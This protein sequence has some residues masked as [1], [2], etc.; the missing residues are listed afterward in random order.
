[1]DATQNEELIEY[2]RN[3]Q[4]WLL[5]PDET[6]A[7]LSPY[8]PSSKTSLNSEQLQTSSRKN[9]WSLTADASD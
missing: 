2:F 7:K 6:P 9:L 5:Q 8:L 4:V 1:M 3:R